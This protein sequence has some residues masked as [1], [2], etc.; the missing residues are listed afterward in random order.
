MAVDFSHRAGRTQVTRTAENTAAYT[1]DAIGQVIGDVAS[2]GTTNR[3]NE[4]LRYAFDPAGNLNYRTN[5]TLIENFQVNTVHPVRYLPFGRSASS[6][7]RLQQPCLTNMMAVSHGVNELTE[8]T[9][10]GKLTVTWPV[11]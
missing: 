1:Y 5:N 2:E 11:R 4:Q 10:G 3:M 9:N 8:N 7:E 6:C